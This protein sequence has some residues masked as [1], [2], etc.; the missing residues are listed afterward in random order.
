MAVEGSVTVMNTRT[1]RRLR[2]VLLL[3]IASALIVVPATGSAQSAS[4]AIILP[5]SAVDLTGHTYGEWSAAWWQY[6]LSFPT[7]T[8]PLL[9]AT[10]ANCAQRQTGNVFFLVGSLAGPGVRDQC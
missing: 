5:E 3:I 1:K 10:G 7:A 6:V 4:F 2:F 9:D 8:N